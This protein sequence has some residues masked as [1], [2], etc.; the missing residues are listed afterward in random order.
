MTEMMVQ[1][2]GTGIM[3]AEEAR[4]MQEVFIK[5]KLAKEF[6]R[7]VNYTMQNILRECENRAL[8]EQAQFEFP[9]GGETVKGPSIRLIEV[10]ARYWGNMVSGVKELSRVRQPDG[11]EVATVKA[12]AW[13]METNY[14]DEKVFD[15]PL[16][17]AT[18][19]GT[20]RLTDPRDQYEMVA[21]QGA[22][23]KRACI[24]AVIPGWVIDQALEQ[25]DKTLEADK[26]KESLETRKEKMLAAFQKH[27]D[28]ITIE[29]LAAYV[30]KEP[31]KLSARDL[32]RLTRVYSAIE[33]GFTKPETVFGQETEQGP[34]QED[35]QAA[36]D[37]LD[38][39][40]GGKE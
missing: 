25:C 14:Q 2:P 9:R 4:E 7:D 33:E 29:H 5:A 15:V 22:R 39:A 18:K 12:F 16:V 24:Q 28:W 31:D 19:K 36:K 3:R 1:S 40:M 26:G 30:G 32:V 38:M 10:I 34:A 17:R 13:D 8:A 35:T 20:Y 23:R 27:A 6:I 11:T 21:N 37:L